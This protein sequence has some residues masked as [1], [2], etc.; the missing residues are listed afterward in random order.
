[1]LAGGGG[2]DTYYVG[3]G[4]TVTEQQSGGIDRVI[5]SANHT[6]RANIENLDLIGN[7]KDGT[8]NS[9]DNVIS[10]N[11]L[12][13]KLTGGG[14]H[15]ELV[16]GGA[17]DTLVGNTGADLFRFNTPTDGGP[18]GDVIVDFD[19]S[20]DLIALENSGFGLA[21]PGNGIF[22]NGSGRATLA[23]YGV[24]FDGSTAAKTAAPTVIFDANTDRL[25][26]DADGTGA[27]AAKL[28]AT[29]SWRQCD[30]CKRFRDRVS[31]RRLPSGLRRSPLRPP[32]R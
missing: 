31:A 18:N 9:L 22:G 3:T 12:A 25:W 19:A 14:G 30:E 23:D 4:D 6:L 32:A 5:A 16:G 17:R 28:L 7:A 15:D 2:N 20:E 27:G 21:A 29:L 11:A 26:W 8:G 1:M 10:G 24:Q 13:N